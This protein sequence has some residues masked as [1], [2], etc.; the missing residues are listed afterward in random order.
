MLFQEHL[1]LFIFPHNYFIRVCFMISAFGFDSIVHHSRSFLFFFNKCKWLGKD[2]VMWPPVTFNEESVVAAAGRTVGRQTS[3]L[4]LFR[5]CPA[6][7]STLSK[8]L[9]LPGWPRVSE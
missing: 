6:S 7:A 8:V 3:A 5:D 4:S 9:P 1:L 2:T